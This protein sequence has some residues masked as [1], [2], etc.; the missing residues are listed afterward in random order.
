MAPPA[1]LTSRSELGHRIS[2][3]ED[4]I[5]V[6]TQGDLLLD[7]NYS[8]DLIQYYRVSVSVLHKQSSYFANLLDG[9]KFSEGIAV[10]LKLSE[11]R[12]SYTDIAAVPPHELPRVKISDIA[13]GPAGADTSLC[14]SAF[15]LLLEILHGCIQWSVV[16]TKAY[17]RSIVLALLAHYSEVFAAI[18]SVSREIQALAAKGLLRGNAQSTADLRENKSRQK[19]YA[20]LILGLPDWVQTHSTALII[21]GSKRWSEEQKHNDIEDNEEYPWDY[22]NGGVEGG[23]LFTPSINAEN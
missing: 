3:P 22:L 13:V 7:I 14:E 10:D 6:D 19:L 20:G 21:W 17:V 23:R 8:K 12:I 2:T 15:G 1:E 18:P 4:P 5:V 9:T 16:K 11:L